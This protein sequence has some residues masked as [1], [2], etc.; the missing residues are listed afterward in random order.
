MK[1]RGTQQYSHS[2]MLATQTEHNITVVRQTKQY[3]SLN[4][5]IILDYRICITIRF[6]VSRVRVAIE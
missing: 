6:K 1:H 3:V 5:Y 2:H 4:K